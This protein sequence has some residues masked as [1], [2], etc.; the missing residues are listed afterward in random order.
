MACGA[1]LAGRRCT[2]FTS[3]SMR[4]SLTCT[5]AG[6]GNPGAPTSSSVCPATTEPTRGTHTITAPLCRLDPDLS[7]SPC[8]FA[9]DCE[10]CVTS[11]SQRCLV[12]VTVVDHGGAVVLNTLVRPEGEVLDAKTDLHG[13]T[14]EQMKVRCSG[15]A[16][17]RQDFRLHAP[18]SNAAA[19]PRD[20]W[21]VCRRRPRRAQRL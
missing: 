13:I 9:V 17:T 18:Q 3:T 16:C 19:Q 5:T 6:H 14:V 11:A 2:R 7:A 20:V 10:M 1:S 15:R 21:C 4:R 12:S 8:L